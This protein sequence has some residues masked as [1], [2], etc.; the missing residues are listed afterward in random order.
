MLFMFHICFCCAALFVPCILVVI[1]L[2]RVA[3]FGLSCGF[4]TFQ[5]GFLGQL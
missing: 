5:Y 2:E 4:V 1:C 3:L